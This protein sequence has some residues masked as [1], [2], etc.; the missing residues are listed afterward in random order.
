MDISRFSFLRLGKPNR[1]GSKILNRLDSNGKK[2][3][4]ID[5]LFSDQDRSGL[6]VWE[7]RC[8]DSGQPRSFREGLVG[9]LGNPGSQQN[10][11]AGAFSFGS[12]GNRLVLE[13]NP[14]SRL[15]IGC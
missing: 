14:E 12:E 6:T 7:A 4:F 5:V 8:G 2:P 15:G 11:C 10:G 9:T 3:P 1:N 13:M